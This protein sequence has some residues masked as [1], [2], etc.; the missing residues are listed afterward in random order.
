MA[1]AG[2]LL[3]LLRPN[4]PTVRLLGGVGLVCA[5][6]F[7]LQPQALGV[8]GNPFLF[9]NNLRYATLGLVVGLVVL[10]I[11]APLVRAQ[12]R[13]WVLGAFG[14]IL[15]ATQLDPS[16]WPTELRDDPFEA[17]VRGR[18]V[19]AGL[20]AGVLVLVVA[21]VGVAHAPRVRARP[22]LVWGAVGA[23]AIGAG[24]FISDDY[25]KDRY[26]RSIPLPATYRWVQGLHDERIGLVGVFLQY[27]FYGEDLSNHVQYVGLEGEHGSYSGARTCRE[28]RRAVD[29]GGYDYVV[30]APPGF[31][32]PFG[33]RPEGLE[34]PWTRAAPAATEVFHEDAVGNSR[35][36]VIRIRGKL[37]P[38][39]CGQP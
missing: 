23:V 12:R 39:A 3:A 9:V 13:W 15:L 35:V 38:D 5:L 19:L 28:W 21:G 37:D 34:A 29:E 8:E 4:P 22:A 11:V 26:A 27:P 32:A 18:P 30:T 25:L 24:W 36:A 2:L 14:A 6:A 31:P 10:P 20:A 33:R 1:G 17:P 16:V 7:L